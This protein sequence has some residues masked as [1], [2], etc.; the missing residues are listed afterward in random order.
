MQ[1][2]QRLGVRGQCLA[3]ELEIALVHDHRASIHERRHRRRQGGPPVFELVYRVV[4]YV[5]EELQP[6]IAHDVRLL[7]DRGCNCAAV[8]PIKCLRVVVEGHNRQLVFHVEAAQRFG[9]AGTPCRFQAN[10]P[11]YFFFL[12]YQFGDLV[13]RPPR[14]SVVIQNLCQLE[15]RKILQRVRH[16]R[17]SIVEVMLSRNRDDRNAPFTWNERR[18]SPQALSASLEV[19]RSDVQHALR[20]RHIRIHADHRDALRHCLVNLG[21]ENL[22]PRRGEADSGGML[23]HDPAE[24]SYLCVGVVRRR[25]DEFSLYAERSGRVQ[26]SRLRLL[27]V[28]Q[29]N[30]RGHEHVAFVF[31]VVGFRTRRNQRCPNENKNRYQRGPMSSHWNSPFALGLACGGVCSRLRNIRA[32]A[33]AWLGKFRT[34]GRV[35]STSTASSLLLS[36]GP[37]FSLSTLSLRETIGRSRKEAMRFLRAWLACILL[38]LDASLVLSPLTLNLPG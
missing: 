9:G 28:R 32:P 38:P 6:V 18:H 14:V 30:I 21:L 1:S 25:T 26:K 16:A 8:D 36:S 34:N 2:L 11:V 23:F 20:I 19:I 37:E 33:H 29:V 10:N 27:P 15:S 4:V 5:V 35:T 17:H 3:I 22:G 31:L 13:K 24:H 7:R 12:L